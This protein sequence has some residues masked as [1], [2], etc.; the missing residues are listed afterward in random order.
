MMY[1]LSSSKVEAPIFWTKHLMSTH[2]IVFITTIGTLNEQL[3]AGAAPIATCLDTSYEPPLI[4]FSTAVKQHSVVGGPANKDQTNTF[5]NIKENR[6]FI[7]NIPNRDLIKKLDILGKPYD[8]EKYKDKIEEAGLKKI[9][10]FKLSNRKIYPP[11][12][13][14]CIGHIEC[15]VIDIHQ[16]QDSDHYN[17]T[18]KVVGVS[19]DKV[20]G[21]DLDEIKINLAKQIF[22]HFGSNK[23]QTE[24]YIGL[25]KVLKM[26][27]S[28]IFQLEK[29]KK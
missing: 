22:H 13:E 28:L 2:P 15:E 25:I 18:G 8:R 9:R 21:T 29:D 26:K 27:S 20:L 4:T 5:L 12:I 7:V 23:D 19:Y 16:P 11:M 1:D 6:S 14:E 24:R 17:I 10:P 3:V